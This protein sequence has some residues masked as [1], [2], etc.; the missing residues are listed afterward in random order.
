MRKRRRTS[1]SS[2]DEIL[3]M[4][5]S[6]ESLG[7]VAEGKIASPGAEAPQL[8][9]AEPQLFKMERT[10]EVASSQRGEEMLYEVARCGK[11]TWKWSQLLQVL[12]KKMDEVTTLAK[13]WQSWEL[14]ADRG[15]V[16]CRCCRCTARSMGD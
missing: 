14:C 6:P 1:S 8:A 13:G 15:S 3:A 2:G 12:D 10:E 16:A 9:V 5:S 4:D 7:A 11:V